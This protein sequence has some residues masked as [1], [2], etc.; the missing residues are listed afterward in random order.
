MIPQNSAADRRPAI[1]RFSNFKEQ[2]PSPIFDERPSW[3]ELY[4]K[5]WELAFR[6]F[7][8]P[9]PGSALVS[10][11]IDAAFNENIF[12][13][14]TC[15]MTMFCD[16]AFPLVPGISSL[17]NFYAR[18]HED[19]EIC[20]E[21][22]RDTGIDFVEWQNREDRALFSRW[23]FN[24]EGRKGP[25]PVSYEG[26]EVPRAQSPPHPGWTEP[27]ALRVVGAR[28]LPLDGRP[29]AACRRLGCRWSATIGRSR[30]T[31]ARATACT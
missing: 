27:P 17:D 12:Q 19:G 2:L 31:C 22:R 23:G 1:P 3:V 9:A 24:L 13:W 11:F 8:A 20:R 30:S 21:I 7:H 5:A 4:G 18:Q 29:R 6:N 28:A 25:F 10:P 14:D 15:F 26:R 16:T